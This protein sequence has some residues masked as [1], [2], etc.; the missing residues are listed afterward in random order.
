MAAVSCSSS[1]QTPTQACFEGSAM[2]LRL[3]LEVSSGLQRIWCAAVILLRF[4]CDQP[5]DVDKVYSVVVCVGLAAAA[6]GL[7]EIAG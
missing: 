2:Q 3:Y 6:H 5:L 7:L 1:P 4:A